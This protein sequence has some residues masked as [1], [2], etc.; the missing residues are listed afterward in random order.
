MQKSEERQLAALANTKKT[1][2]KSYVRTQVAGKAIIA[3]SL[4]DT[5]NL[6]G[7][8][9]SLDFVR[10]C[11]L[12]YQPLNKHIKAGTA[13]QASKL[14]I[15]GKIPQLELRFEGIPFTFKDDFYVTRNLSYPINIGLAFLSK[16]SMSIQLKPPA[17]LV[18][19]THRAKLVSNNA[20]TLN[21]QSRDPV[22]AELST[23]ID[24]I[25]PY[26][27]QPFVAITSMDQPVQGRKEKE[28]AP[29]LECQSQR[30]KEAKATRGS[31]NQRQDQRRKR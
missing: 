8:S 7:S 5:G 4:L 3:K 2:T 27:N 10:K 30:R 22:I 13:A 20:S 18:Y 21:Q 15:V 26:E 19:R 17:S 29:S 6:L 11:G 14:T 25:K 12:N 9:V 16:H 24:T 1:S 23:M 28:C 31:S